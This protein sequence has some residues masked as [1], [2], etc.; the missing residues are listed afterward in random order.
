MT[1]QNEHFHSVEKGCDLE[2]ITVFVSHGHID[3]YRCKTH[4]ADYVCRC[5]WEYGWHYGTDSN[6]GKFIDNRWKRNREIRVDSE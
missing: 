5:G 1:Y 2:P 4:N 6:S 3:A